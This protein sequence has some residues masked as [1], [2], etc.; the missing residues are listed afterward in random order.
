MI[1]K[2]S[3]VQLTKDRRAM[4]DRVFADIYLDGRSVEDHNGWE[5]FEGVKSNDR[6]MNTWTKVIFLRAEKEY[7]PTEKAEL[8]ILF[9]PDSR[10]P[11]AAYLNGKEI[12]LP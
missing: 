11:Q 12:Q 8:A 6:I 5:F 7:E 10:T 3:S 9:E 1:A 4:A 2:T